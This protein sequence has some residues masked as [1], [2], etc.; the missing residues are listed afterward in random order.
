MR[1]REGGTVIAG[2]SH[3]GLGTGLRLSSGDTAAR[4]AALGERVMDGVLGGVCVCVLGG[5][6]DKLSNGACCLGRREG[7]I[8]RMNVA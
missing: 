1:R 8:D 6:E 5:A 4:F 2:P 3:C 7:S